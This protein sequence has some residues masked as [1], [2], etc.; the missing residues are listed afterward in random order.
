MNPR[1]AGL[2]LFL[3][4][5][6]LCRAQWDLRDLPE[7]Q[8]QQKVSG[9]IRMVGTPFRGAVQAWEQAFVKYQPGVNFTNTLDSSDIAM[10]SMIL[11]T[12]DIASSGREPSLE[13]ILGFTEKHLHG[14]TPLVVAS[15]AWNT[16]GGASWSPV[17]FVSKDNPITRLTMAQVD[18][19]FG[20]ERTGGYAE[21]SI[22]WSTRGARGREKDIRTW[23]DLGLGGEWKDKPIQTYGYA[24]TGMRHFFELQVFD[25]GTKWNPNYREYVD[26]GTKMVEPGAANGS[27]DMLVALSHDKYGIGWSGNGHA[28]SVEG[29]KAVALARSADGP[30]FEP[31]AQNMQ[32]RDYPLTRSV[33][34]YI[35]RKPGE[36]V[37]PKVREFLRFVLSRE[38]QEI[39]AKGGNQLPLPRQAVLEQRKKLD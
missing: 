33:F 20:A 1:S 3:M 5:A 31:N 9:T 12:A 17:V 2:F 37:D 14:V 30:Y 26:T 16:P 25:G 6:A 28:A 4:G 32:R 34:M 39:L 35:D 8:P 13:E 27:H 21:N 18:G 10:A 7:Y 19:I 22:V 29:L 36:P 11:G 24:P 15:G 23:G 38:G